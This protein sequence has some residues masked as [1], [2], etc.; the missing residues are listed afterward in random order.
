MWTVSY[1]VYAHTHISRIV[2]TGR[3]RV[4]LALGLWVRYLIDIPCYDKTNI[5]TFRNWKMWV[6]EGKCMT[7]TS[8]DLNVCLCTLLFV[9]QICWRQN[10]FFKACYFLKK[11]QEYRRYFKCLN[12]EAFHCSLKVH[13]TVKAIS[14]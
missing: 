10:C 4:K 8:V 2:T 14:H 13:K 9:Q 11:E 5:Y 3:E 12:S 1:V 7:T 6:S